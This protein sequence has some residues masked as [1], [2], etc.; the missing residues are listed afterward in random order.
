[1]R[2]HSLTHPRRILC[3]T[4]G[5][6]LTPLFFAPTLAGADEFTSSSFKVLDPVI[7]PSGYGTS[8]GFRLWGS[9]SQIAI[10]TSSAT[11]FKLNPG[12]LFF[13]FASTPAVSTTAGDAQVALSWSASTGILGWT[14]SSYSVGQATAS[15]G[16]Y[17]FTTLGN[18]TSSTRTGLTNATTYYFVIRALDAFDNVVATSTEVSATPVAPTTTSTTP[19]T[20]GGGGGYVPVSST[21]VI[22]SGRAYPLSTVVLLKDAQVAVR[23]VAGPDAKFEITLSGLSPGDY[24][25]SLHSEDRDGRRSSLVIFPIMLSYGATTRVGGVFIPPTIDVDKAE[26]RRG[27]NIAI[28]GQTVPESNV[29]INV[30]SNNDIFLPTESDEDGVYYSNFDTSVLEYGGHTARSKS[31]LANTV[32][33]FGYLVNFKVGE[34]N[35]MKSI[36]VKSLKGD[37]NNDG[38]VNLVDFSIAAFWYKR[39]LSSTFMAVES[40]RLS[41]DGKVD[42]GDFSIMAFYW[43]G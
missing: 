15:G 24:L 35:V 25:F 4:I 11:S 22:F 38:R 31:S 27:D 39:T 19:S 9:V 26:V 12:F 6:I 23:T 36:S 7:V 14:V 3:V 20:G 16:P 28:F 1:M 37:L 2:E 5:I 42:L 41:G 8:A 40:E 13:P 21:G 30:N 10:G 43:T 18:V 17:S 34:A 33:N 32:S 29:V